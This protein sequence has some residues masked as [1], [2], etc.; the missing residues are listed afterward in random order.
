MDFGHEVIIKSI[1]IK[2]LKIIN[3]AAFMKIS[4]STFRRNSVL[5]TADNAKL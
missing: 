2:T 1:Q 4:T 3:F 5:K